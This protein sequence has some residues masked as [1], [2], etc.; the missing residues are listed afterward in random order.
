VWLNVAQE[1]ARTGCDDACG[2]G[3]G[4]AWSENPVAWQWTTQ[5]WIARLGATLLA[6]AGVLFAARRGRLA[7]VAAGIS[8][9]LLCIWYPMA[10]PARFGPPDIA[11]TQ[12]QVL[13]PSSPGQTSR[14]VKIQ[15]HNE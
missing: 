15:V 4:P 2:N 3:I 7:L 11:A 13:A 1:V 8:L 9:I 6:T 12:G 10:Q 5:L 14:V